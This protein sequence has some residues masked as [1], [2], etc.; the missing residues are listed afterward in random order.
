MDLT[1]I[2][3]AGSMYSTAEDLFRWNQAM[4]SD[5]VLS[6]E[7]RDEIFRPGLGDWG[8]GW[9]ITTI[10]AN[11]PGAGAKL[12]EMRGDMPGNFFCSINR[13]PDQDAVI[14]V[15]RNGYGSS[16][17]LE[18]NLQAVLFDQKPRMPWRK[19]A[20]VVVGALESKAGFRLFALGLATAVIVLV[21]RRRLAKTRIGEY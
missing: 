14:I 3:A 2:Y 19:P 17:R 10:Q 6:K 1:H 16:E 8:Y 20:E 7:I 9:F 4:S 18:A 12:A 13:Y 15:L 11:Q 5:A 21:G